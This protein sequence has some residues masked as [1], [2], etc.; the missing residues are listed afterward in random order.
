MCVAMS[1]TATTICG[2]KERTGACTS[3]CWRRSPPTYARM[4][5]HLIAQYML[6]PVV[7]SF[8]HRKWQV[9]QRWRAWRADF[10][11]SYDTVLQVEVNALALAASFILLDL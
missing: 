2:A 6:K 3:P 7:P 5:L 1:Q 9:V 11:S 10:T 8:L 4:T